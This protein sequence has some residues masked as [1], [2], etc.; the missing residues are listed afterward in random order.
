MVLG[1][2][3]TQAGM[4]VPQRARVR[5]E[6]GRAVIDGADRLLWGCCTGADE[7]AAA[8]ARAVG[9]RLIGL[10]SREPGDPYRSGLVSDT[11]LMI[12]K[13]RNPEL[14]RNGR[15][16]RASHRLI[17]APKNDRQKIIGRAVARGCPIW[18]VVRRSGT[19]ATVRY[20]VNHGTPVI[21][22]WPDGWATHLSKGTP[23]G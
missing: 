3:G 18:E 16:G 11:T 23:H 12:P 22:V 19:W 10:P 9:L 4:A 7:E 13:G 2:T 8:D 5:A 21:V 14:Q 20:A 1:F 6:I 15:I 17:A